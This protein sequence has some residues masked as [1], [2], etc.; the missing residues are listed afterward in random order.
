M[1]SSAQDGSGYFSDVLASFFYGLQSMV[2]PYGCVAVDHPQ[3]PPWAL[4]RDAGLFGS[5][6]TS[7]PWA[8]E[9]SSGLES[10]QKQDLWET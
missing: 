9:V 6:Q 2:I 3:P 7:R 1:M 8:Y 10:F 4:G 5:P